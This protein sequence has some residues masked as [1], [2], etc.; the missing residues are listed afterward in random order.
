MK[1]FALLGFAFA[2][3]TTIEFQE[4]YPNSFAKQHVE[5]VLPLA[6]EKALTAPEHTLTRLEA[7]QNRSVGA[8]GTGDFTEVNF[9]YVYRVDK[10][11][12]SLLLPVEEYPRVIRSVYSDT[13]AAVGKGGGKVMECKCEGSTFLIRYKAAIGSR[14]TIGT[15]H[16]W[17]NEN[18]EH[19]VISVD[20][21]EETEGK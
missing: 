19:S 2:G 10:D 3:C 12:K 4:S 13:L 8:W 16:G 14:P 18:S 15:I 6:A 20:V 7:N 21:R 1:K 17:I 11:G 5:A 9:R